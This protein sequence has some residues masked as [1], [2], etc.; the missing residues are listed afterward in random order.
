MHFL[1]STVK[2]RAISL[3]QK[4]PGVHIHGMSYRRK[5]KTHEY[6]GSLNIQEPWAEWT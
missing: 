3:L 2:E 5:V 4:F 1:K 6:A